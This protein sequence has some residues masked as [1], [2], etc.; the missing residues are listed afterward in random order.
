MSS[1]QVGAPTDGSQPNRPP[2]T[3]QSVLGTVARMAF[4]YWLMSYFRGNN[5]KTAQTQDPAAFTAP[6]FSKG[7]SVDMYLFVNERWHVPQGRYDMKDLLWSEEGLPLAD[8]ESVRQ[9]S[10]D[11]SI[12]PAVQRNG[13]LYMHVVFAKTGKT[14]DPD[15]P[16]YNEELVF[17][18][19]ER[20]TVHLPRPK[21]TTGVNLLTSDVQPVVP[22]TGPREIVNFIKPNVTIQIVDHFVGYPKTQIPATVR[23]WMQFGEDDNYYPLIYFNDFWLLRDKLVLVN[24]TLPSITLHFDF[25]FISFF[26]WQL[27]GQMTKSFETQMTMGMQQEGESDELKRVFLE[28]THTHTALTMVVSLLHTVFDMLAFKNDIGFW[29]NNKSM[30]GLSARSVLINAFCQLVILLYLFDNETSFVVLLSAVLGTAIEFWKVTKAMD[31]SFDPSRFPY[32][33]LSDRASYD[34]NDTKK[35]D[36]DAMR[37]L[38]YALYPLVGGYAIYALLYKSHKSWYSWIVSSLV[39]AVYMFGFILMCPQLY[40]N[41]KLKSVAALP[42]RQMTYKFLNTIIDDLFAFVIKMPTMHRLAVFR[43]D[44]VFLIYIYQRWIYPI[45]KTRVN[46]FG[47]QAEP[48]DPQQPQ[49]EAAGDGATPSTAIEDKKAQEG[50]RSR[51]RKAAAAQQDAPASD[52]GASEVSQAPKKDS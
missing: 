31:V 14:I 17:G 52:A 28:D 24:E 32:I 11:I 1:Q 38:S 6:K 15:D 21:N 36:E 46:E 27:Q 12:P 25:G 50:G 7:T 39:G 41:Y 16:G 22:E 47:F 26:W 51:R 35:H 48:T 19:T 3:V 9:K 30:E 2:V 34:V 8:P 18:R 49:L 29:K 20:L 42:W 45:D 33:K 13:T 23:P 37:Y 40:L 4:M 44:L 5:Q 10:V 43:D